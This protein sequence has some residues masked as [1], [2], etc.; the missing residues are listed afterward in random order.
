L[1]TR[2]AL[3]SCQGAKS[4]GSYSVCSSGG[5]SCTVD[6]LL[7]RGFDVREK[8]V[9]Q[10]SRGREEPRGR[11]LGRGPRRTRLGWSGAWRE[12]RR[13]GQ[14]AGCWLLRA[15]QGSASAC[16]CARPGQA[17]MGPECLPRLLHRRSGLSCPPLPNNALPPCVALSLHRWSHRRPSI[18]GSALHAVSLLA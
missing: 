11:S 10:G 7:Q 9:R 15:V 3:T 17:S 8:P 1:K 5:C 13:G 6:V 4:Q 2:R 12:L 14:A 16:A 18:S